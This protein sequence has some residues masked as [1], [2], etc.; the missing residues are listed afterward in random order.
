M[1]L[2]SERTIVHLE[3]DRTDRKIEKWQTAA[4]EAA[5]QCGNPYV[6]EILPVQPADAFMQASRGYDLKLIASLQPGAKS[7]KSVLPAI[8]SRK[9]PRGAQGALA[10][11]P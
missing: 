8:R 2:E 6:P 1:P 3:G 5:K 4:V 11:R 9:R 7:L 10:G